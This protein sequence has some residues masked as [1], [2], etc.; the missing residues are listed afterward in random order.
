MYELAL[1][2]AK[3]N[4]LLEASASLEAVRND[5]IKQGNVSMESA[6]EFDIRIPGFINARY[7]LESFSKRPSMTNYTASLEFLDGMHKGVIAGL[8][9]AGLAICAKI[10]HWAFTKFDLFGE[11]LEDSVTASASHT[12]DAVKDVESTASE[13]EI[14]SATGELDLIKD[15]GYNA[16]D[17][18]YLS[19]TGMEF[20]SE[21]YTGDFLETAFKQSNWILDRLEDIIKHGP[22]VKDADK[23]QNGDLNDEIRPKLAGVF[24]A[25]E[26]SS[27]TKIPRAKIHEMLT[28]YAAKL[29]G[30]TSAPALGKPSRDLYPTI[31][32][33]TTTIPKEL[34]RY[35]TTF[36]ALKNEAAKLDKRFKAV[37]SNCEANKTSIDGSAKVY[38]EHVK[39]VSNCIARYTRLVGIVLVQLNTVCDDCTKFVKLI[40]KSL[41]KS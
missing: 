38:I 21:I 31:K 27:H 12:T 4:E 40:R 10:I 28:E 41:H 9:V 17:E 26:R 22:S 14:I 13:S 16:L 11:D 33:F 19:R 1:E 39:Y 2:E 6:Q 36:A 32:A 34:G 35:V 3:Y 29:H 30:L 24:N 20:I 18:F 15:G 37:Q 23:I 25:L 5:L 8:I 7:P